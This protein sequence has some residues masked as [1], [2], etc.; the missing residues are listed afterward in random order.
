MSQLPSF[1]PPPDFADPRLQNGFQAEHWPLCD[2][3]PAVAPN[4]ADLHRRRC[5]EF[6]AAYYRLNML[7]ARLLLA[8]SNHCSDEVAQ[9]L[10]ADVAAATADLDQL[11]DRYAPIG[12]FGEPV[13]EGMRYHSIEFIRPE[14]PRIYPTASE[15]C[16]QFTIPGLDEIPASEL[17]GPS[18]II[19]F[20]HGKIDL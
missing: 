20:G 17:T 5:L 1:E 11:E 19:R 16:V 14:L 13:M 2:G 15:I 3:N 10:L 18:R 7:N 6:L 8:R 4:P 12:F 9:A